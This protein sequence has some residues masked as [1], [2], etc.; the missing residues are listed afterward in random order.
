MRHLL[1]I[2]LCFATLISGGQQITINLSGESI[3]I[4][5]HGQPG[6]FPSFTPGNHHPD[7]S[8]SFTG[9]RYGLYR[10]AWPE[11]SRGKSSGKLGDVY[12]YHLS[13]GPVPLPLQDPFSIT[14]NFPATHTLIWHNQAWEDGEAVVMFRDY[15]TARE[16]PLILVPKGQWQQKPSALNRV[17]TMQVFYLWTNDSLSKYLPQAIEAVDTAANDI[18]LFAPSY[19]HKRLQN[20]DGVIYALTYIISEKIVTGLEHINSPL[21]IS[22]PFHMK[23]YAVDHTLLHSFI[24][25]GMVPKSYMKSDGGYHPSDALGWYEGLTTFLANNFI[26][27]DF[28]DYFSANIFRAKLEAGQDSLPKLWDTRIEAY[29]AKGYLF[30]IAMEL[31]GLNVH[32]YSQ[33]L[34]SIYAATKP[35]PLEVEWKDVVQSIYVFNPEL[36]R[37][38]EILA[39]GKYL[40]AFDGLKERGWSPIPLSEMVRWYDLYIGP[41]PVTPGG[42][43]LPTDQYDLISSYPVALILEGKELPLEPKKDNKALRIIKDN[44][45]TAYSVRFSDGKS[46]AI[47]DDLSFQD[48]APYF[49]SGHLELNAQN[50]YFWRSLNQFLGK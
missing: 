20:Y 45:Q 9:Q 24:G 13:S 10:A 23:P 49:M 47:K 33:W 1:A 22:S 12:I 21:C 32:L 34:F 18:G 14:V 8:M 40:E 28:A 16:F 19:W 42:I 30:W 36:G 2:F 37:K 31:Q 35:F 15:F 43:Q 44:P 26:R 39:G 6:V 46:R 50:I 27:H 38:A 3:N 17:D 48:G 11:F 4:D 41:Y 5:L 25:K 7:N 29:Y